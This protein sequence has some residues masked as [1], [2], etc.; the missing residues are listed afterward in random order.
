MIIKKETVGNKVYIEMN[1][2]E[3]LKLPSNVKTD[4]ECLNSSL[5]SMEQNQHHQHNHDQMTVHK[6][7]EF[8]NAL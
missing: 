4:S 3:H 7:T 1:L 8:I 2:K 5:K 6:V